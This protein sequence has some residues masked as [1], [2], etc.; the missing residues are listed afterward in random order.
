MKIIGLTGGVASGKNFIAEIFRAR[1]ALIFDADFIV[2]QILQNDKSTID[3]VFNAFPQAFIDNKIDRKILGKIVFSDSKK[4]KILE[5]IIHPIV[6]KKYNLF[7]QNAHKQKAKI[8]VLNIPLLLESNSYKC[9]CVVAIITS[10]LLQKFR[11]LKRE[12]L[13]DKDANFTDLEN[14]FYNILSSQINNLE[15]KKR[16]DFVIYNSSKSAATRQVNHFLNLV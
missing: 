3:Q 1:K 6:R 7:L 4:L 10:K 8:V 16:A 5:K 15:R 12:K 2:H 13:K 14:K 9:D 11:F